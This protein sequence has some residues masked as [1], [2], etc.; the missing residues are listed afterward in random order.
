M[1]HFAELDENNI[2]LRVL[3]ISNDDIKDEDGNESEAVG[4]TFCETISDKVWVQTSYNNNIRK[5][6]AFPGFTYDA[7]RDAFIE[8]QPFPSWVL[9][10][11]TCRW[12]PPI[13]LPNND[14]FYSW[15][16]P[17]MTWIEVIEE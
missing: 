14:K 8:P 7:I 5:N 10:K 2:V 15:N 11:E 1:A 13:P 12:E 6:F 9:N 3:V 4:K 17:T 16:E